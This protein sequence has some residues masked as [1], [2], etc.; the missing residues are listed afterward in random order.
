MKFASFTAKPA[1]G[2][3]GHILIV[4]FWDK[5]MGQFI[6]FPIEVNAEESPF[7]VAAHLGNLADSII[8]E[9]KES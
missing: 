7:F 9:F 6:S 2:S 3:D 1:K 4:N 5:D 8:Q